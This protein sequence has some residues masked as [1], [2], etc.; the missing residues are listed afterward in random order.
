MRHLVY[1]LLLLTGMLLA[2]FWYCALLID[3]IQEFS[4]GYYAH[5]RAEEVLKTA[6]IVLYTYLGIRFF[7]KKINFPG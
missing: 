3:W 1:S 5:H 4:S 6:G 7:R 2:F